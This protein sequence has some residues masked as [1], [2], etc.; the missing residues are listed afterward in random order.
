MDLAINNLCRKRK[1]LS[2]GQSQKVLAYRIIGFL[3][4]IIDYKL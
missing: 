1:K 4:Q 2:V 3:N